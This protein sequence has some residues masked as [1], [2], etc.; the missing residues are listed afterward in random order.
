MCRWHDPDICWQKLLEFKKILSRQGPSLKSIRGNPSYSAGVEL[1]NCTQLPM[2]ANRTTIC[3]SGGETGSLEDHKFFLWDCANGKIGC[4]THLISLQ[5]CAAHV[6]LSWNNRPCSSLH[7]KKSMVQW[8]GVQTATMRIAGGQQKRNLWRKIEII[9]VFF[10]F[11]NLKGVRMRGL[12]I[13]V[14]KYVNDKCKKM[15]IICSS[16]PEWIK[17]GVM[18]FNGLSEWFRL[19]FRRIFLTKRIV[20]HWS[21]LSEKAMAAPVTEGL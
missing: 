17:Q 10:C 12:G 21:R 8:G 11:L 1:T 4:K 15:G 2:G 6:S 9:C 7:F 16:Y 19:G 3:P 18:V 14:F 20:T 13:L 5:L